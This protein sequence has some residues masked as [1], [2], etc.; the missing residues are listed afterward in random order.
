MLSLKHT[1]ILSGMCYATFP[2]SGCLDSRWPEAEA[3]KCHSELPATK[4]KC[5]CVNII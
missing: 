2:C 4:I 5:V 1:L 3:K